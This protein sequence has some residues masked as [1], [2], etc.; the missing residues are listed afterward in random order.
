M[1]DNWEDLEKSIVNCNKCKLCNNRTNIV[2]GVGNKSA[3]VMLIGEGPGA[4]EDIQGI[5][6]V[7]KAGQF[8]PILPG[9]GGGLLMRE[10]DGKYYSATGAKGY[11]WLESEVVKELHK[12]KDIDKSYYKALVDE[13]VDTISNYCDFEY[14]TSD[15][16]LLDI[17]SDELPY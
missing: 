17:Y 5:P 11:R 4:D 12:E 3:D 9:K 13:A 7:G 10:K 14:F 1:F 2:F 16:E 6:F 15:S 8:C